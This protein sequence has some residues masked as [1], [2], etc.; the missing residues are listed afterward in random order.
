[1][2]EVT[3]EIVYATETAEYHVQEIEFNTSDIVEITETEDDFNLAKFVDNL[4]FEKAYAATSGNQTKDGWDS[5]Y[6]V[7]GRVTVYYKKDNSNRYLIT[8]VSG[9]YSN[10]D[11]SI[12]ITDQSV[13]VACAGG[14]S[15]GQKKSFYPGTSSSWSYN[16][17]FSTYVTPAIYAIGGGQ[18]TINLK[19]NS[20]RWSLNVNNILFS[21]GSMPI[22]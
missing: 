9:G 14:E 16:T 8:S 20:S 4:F 5:S 13:A 11:S 12:Q 18:V 17:G 10:Y 15:S 21:A 3:D 6:G 1:M 19:R 7:N 22:R 2:A